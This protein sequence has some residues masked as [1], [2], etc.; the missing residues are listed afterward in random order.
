MS[1][2]LTDQEKKFFECY[3]VKQTSAGGFELSY[4]SGIETDNVADED[5]DDNLQAARLHSTKAFREPPWA[6]PFHQQERSHNACGWD[7]PHGDEMN[8]MLLDRDRISDAEP[9]DVCLIDGFEK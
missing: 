6:C 1:G 3:G 7:I 8:L 5:S 9:S 4:R 2:C